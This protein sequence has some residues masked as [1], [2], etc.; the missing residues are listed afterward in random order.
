MDRDLRAHGWTVAGSLVVA[1]GATLAGL[2]A[3]DGRVPLVMLGFLVFILGYLLS[4]RGVHAD[5]GDPALA[6]PSRPDPATVGRAL[7]LVVGWAGISLGVTL[8]SRT[9]L[10]PSPTNAVLSGVA[11]IGGYMAAHVGINGVG[12][13]DSVF[14]PVLDRLQRSPGGEP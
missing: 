5:E 6:T 12:V 10:E 14:G 11:S 9:V 1:S 13:G 4:Q 8:F 2:S 7:L 3:F